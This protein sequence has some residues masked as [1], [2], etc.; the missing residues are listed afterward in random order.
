[1]KTIA[2][3]IEDAMLTRLDRLARAAASGGG[4]R[5]KNPNRS[6]VVRRALGEFL[7]RQEQGRSEERDR[8]ALAA[9]RTALHRQMKALVAEQAD[10]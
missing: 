5:R 4:G 1:M 9:H 2:I 8:A 6:L 10:V 3:T 7:Q